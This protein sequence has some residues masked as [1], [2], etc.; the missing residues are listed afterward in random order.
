MY[1]GEA[2]GK[3]VDLC[4]EE[5]G[6]DFHSSQSFHYSSN[7]PKEVK[8][9]IEK[10]VRNRTVKKNLSQQHQK[11]IEQHKPP[12]ITAKEKIVEEG[13]KVGRSGGEVE[14]KVEEK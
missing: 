4:R 13:E 14:E 7:N 2:S 1:R 6:K 12:E 9:F 11:S 5:T 10:A 3:Q 8:R